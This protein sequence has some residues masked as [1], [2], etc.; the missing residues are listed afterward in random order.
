MIRQALNEVCGKQ[1]L[2]GQLVGQT[3][4]MS[5]NRHPSTYV[6]IQNLRHHYSNMKRN[7]LLSKML[8]FTVF[9]MLPFF[10]FFFRVMVEVVAEM[11][12]IAMVTTL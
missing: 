12:M 7:I 1:P 8:I 5:W 6:L 11:A 2:S 4:I 10:F 9:V 3:A